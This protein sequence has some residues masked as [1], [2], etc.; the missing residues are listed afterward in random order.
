M[1]GKKELTDLIPDIHKALLKGGAP[2]EALVDK[3]TEVFREILSTRFNREA[4]TEIRMSNIGSPCTRKVWYQIHSLSDS[5]MESLSGGTYL[6]FLYGDIIEALL[7]FLVEYS[8]HS[9]EGTQDEQ[10]VL[11]IKGHRDAVI[12]GVL[13]DIKSASPYGFKK[14]VEHRVQ[15]DDPFGYYMQ[16]QSYLH[17]AKD[18]PKVTEKDYAAFL[19]MEKVSGKLALDVYPRTDIDI[20]AEYADK[21]ETLNGKIPPPRGFFPVKDGASGNEKLPVS[22][23]Y[24]PAKSICHPNLRTFLYSTGPRFLTKVVKEPL[25]PETILSPNDLTKVMEE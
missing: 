16:L 24:C 4:K 17:A 2:S 15:E 21:K 5:R 1:T 6:K 8:G 22:C 25:V 14:F 7:L 10:E 13:V 20:E 3:Y 19:V 18:D 11:G 9:V 12:D 23:S